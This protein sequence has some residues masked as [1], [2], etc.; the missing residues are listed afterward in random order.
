MQSKYN[1]QLYP[2]WIDA[3]KQPL[4]LIDAQAWLYAQ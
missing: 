1:N 4:N 2:E 3:I